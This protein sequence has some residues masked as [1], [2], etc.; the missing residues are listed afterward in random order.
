M[1]K[2]LLSTRGGE[3]HQDKT[4]VQP[5]RTAKKRRGSRIPSQAFPMEA[6]PFRSTL[7]PMGQWQPP[8][9]SLP[10]AEPPRQIDRLPLPRGAQPSTAVASPLPCRS[11]YSLGIPKEPL[12]HLNPL[13]PLVSKKALRSRPSGWTEEPPL[14]A[15]DWRS[16][17]PDPEPSSNERRRRS[18][19]SPGSPSPSVLAVQL[20]ETKP[21]GA[22]YALF[23][24]SS[25]AI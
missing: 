24:C 22:H 1:T 16:I 19:A 8:D 18:P 20:S 6:N 14:N 21:S 9:G 2:T 15:F 7:E 12:E 3:Q 17:G 5:H 23:S 13:R 10:K 25:V 11:W 4:P